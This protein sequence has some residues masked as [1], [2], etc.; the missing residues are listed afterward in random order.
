MTYFKWRINF[1][2]WRILMMTYKLSM[3]TYLND[4]DDGVFACIKNG[5]CQE[6]RILTVV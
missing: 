4:N 5:V 2:L 3:M 6:S 1:Q